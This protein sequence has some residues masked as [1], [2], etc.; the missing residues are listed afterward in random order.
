MKRVPHNEIQKALQWE[1]QNASK[2]ATLK[3]FNEELLSVTKEKYHQLGA[4]AKVNSM[5]SES[6]SKDQEL[7]KPKTTTALVEIA[8]IFC[9][10]TALLRKAIFDTVPDKFNVGRG[11]AAQT[12]SITS[13]E[14]WGL[15]TLRIWL[16]S[17]H[18][19]LTPW[20]Q[21]NKESSSGN[22]SERHPTQWWGEC[23]P[24]NR[25]VIYGGWTRTS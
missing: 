19:Y 21:G 11:L 5:D 24:R 3:N 7:R 1:K 10:C 2:L 14:E 9:Q 4:H 8:N 6:K 15:I 13:L 23:S 12:P 25:D 16:N 22:Q 18:Q 20:F 17:Y